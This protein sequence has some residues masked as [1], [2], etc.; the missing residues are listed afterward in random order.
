ML[1]DATKARVLGNLILPLQEEEYQLRLLREAN[2]SDDGDVV[3]GQDYTYADRLSD[4]AGA[5]ERLL[6][7]ADD[8]IVE[9]LRGFRNGD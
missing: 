3:P 5:Q 9:R 2:G 7:A 8:R 6:S 1:T 4:L